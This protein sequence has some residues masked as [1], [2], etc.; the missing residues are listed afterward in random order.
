MGIALTAGPGQIKAPAFEHDRG[1]A[2][3]VVDTRRCAVGAAQLPDQLGEIAVGDEI[4]VDG[5]IAAQQVAD[6]PAHEVDAAGVP[7]RIEEPAGRGQRGQAA[8][9]IVCGRGWHTAI[10]ARPVDAGPAA[11][12][13]PSPP[14]QAPFRGDGCGAG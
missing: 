2:E 6:R 1:R 12:C 9:Q 7:E 4:E 5:G 11:I 13:L 10:I 14:C 8:E 3:S